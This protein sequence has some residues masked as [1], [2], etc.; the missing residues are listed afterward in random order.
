MNRFLL[1]A[2][3]VVTVAGLTT[4]CRSRVRVRA[5]NATVTVHPPPPPQGSVAVSVGTPAV[6]AGSG[7]TVVHAA[8]DPSAPEICNG[9][10]DNCN[11]VIDEGCGYESG[12]IQITLAWNTG[13]DLDM[14]VTDPMGQ[15]IYYANRQSASGGVLDHDA[16]GA[17]APRRANAT[18]EN[19]YWNTPR[20]PSGQYQVDVHYWGDCNVAGVTTATLS[21]A[22]GGQ[23]IGAYNVM[24]RPGERQP[25]A[26]FTIP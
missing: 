14:Y 23:I 5:P 19:V 26:M 13:A 3:A 8:C 18:V 21:I 10:D 15:T 2:L 24:L 20:P 4:G 25:V 22:V 16:R 11:G 9:L 7:V 6:S 1:L 17:C 12:Q